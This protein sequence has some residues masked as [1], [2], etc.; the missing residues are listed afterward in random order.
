MA[1]VSSSRAT[2]RPDSEAMAAH[3]SRDADLQDKLKP[4]VEQMEIADETRT[5]GLEKMEKVSRRSLWNRCERCQ[6][7]D[8]SGG[9]G[10]SESPLPPF[11]PTG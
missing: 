1:I 3:Y 11:P 5:K 10:G 9:N 4:A 7:I 6:G 8:L 2:R